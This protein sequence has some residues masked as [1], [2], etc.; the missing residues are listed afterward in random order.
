MLSPN[1]VETGLRVPQTHCFNELP[2][3]HI[4]PHNTSRIVSLVPLRYIS[5]FMEAELYI[6]KLLICNAGRLTLCARSTRVPIHALC[7]PSHT[8]VYIGVS[9]LRLLSHTHSRYLASCTVANWCL[10]FGHI[11]HLPKALV[12]RFCIR[13]FLNLG[14]A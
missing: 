10:I 5:S 9:F 2:Y 12:L 3:I 7:D 1:T 4:P 13:R 6:K 8:C 11:R 14:R